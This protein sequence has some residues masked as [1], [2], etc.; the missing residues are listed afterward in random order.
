[1]TMPLGGN[2]LLISVAICTHRRPDRL[3]ALLASLERQNYSGTDV[4]VVIIENDTESSAS[5]RRVF[6]SHKAHL[7]LI[8]VLE[9][10]IGLS[11]AR[12]TAL[13]V[14][15]GRYIA[16]LDDDAEADCGWL[17]ALVDE[18]RTTQPHVCGGPIYP[19]YRSA[20]SDW[21]LDRYATAYTYGEAPRWLCHGEW[22]GGG[23]LTLD[24]RLCME[25][26]GFRT[27]LGMAGNTIAYGEETELLMRA[28]ANHPELR[29]RFSPLA[30]IHH[31]VRAEKMFLSW[32][33][34]AAWAGGKSGALVNPVARRPAL[35]ELLRSMTD[36]PE[37]VVAALAFLRRDGV[38]SQLLRQGAYE[39]L[40]LWVWVLSRNWHW[41]LAGKP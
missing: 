4:E 5:V 40:Y 10:S 1:M 26:G 3:D 39:E 23:N 16:Y 27:D 41:F 33:F 13:H 11:R 7:N 17:A 19:L 6:E 12:N 30:C 18:C 28:W 20:K 31:E 36:L 38:T 24:R 9:S 21:F 22:L 25:L 29:V 8:H 34:K 2:S 32:R 14:A 37:R 15:K 35:R